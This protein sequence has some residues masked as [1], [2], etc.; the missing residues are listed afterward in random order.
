[1]S[2]DSAPSTQTASAAHSMP[3]SS[4]VF[5]RSTRFLSIRW[6]MS[7]LP[8]DVGRWCARPCD[9]QL[10]PAK[11][12]VGLLKCDAC[13]RHTS[14]LLPRQDFGTSRL[15]GSNSSLADFAAVRN[16]GRRRSWVKPVRLGLSQD[17]RFVP[18]TRHLRVNEYTLT[19]QALQSLRAYGRRD[20][21]V[22]LG[23]NVGP[24]HLGSARGYL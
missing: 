24:R 17:F 18:K 7:G 14:C 12:S 6:V 3:S 20:A 1:M 9:G 22:L 10:T 15:K 4:T 16:T 21:G 23:R 11:R 5:A 19:P 2:K 13:R 8:F